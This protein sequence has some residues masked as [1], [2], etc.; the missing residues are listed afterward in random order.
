[1]ADKKLDRGK[2]HRKRRARLRRTR[3]RSRP[4]CGKGNGK[5]G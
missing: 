3:R 1:M 5:A 4:T 2:Y